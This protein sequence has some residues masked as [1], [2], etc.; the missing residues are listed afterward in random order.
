MA[1]GY[2]G[3]GEIERQIMLGANSSRHWPGG[4]EEERGGGRQVALTA[5]RETM[6]GKPHQGRLVTLLPPHQSQHPFLR[7]SSSIVLVHVDSL[8]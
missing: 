3:G 5:T 4:E 8:V 7:G 2:M 6:G 1:D